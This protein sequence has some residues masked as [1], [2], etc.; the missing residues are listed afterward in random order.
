[1]ISPSINLTNVSSAILNFWIY[2]SGGSDFLQVFINNN[3]GAFTQ[4]GTNYGIYNNW[5]LI[6]I[7]IPSS[8]VGGA[9]SNVKLKFTGLS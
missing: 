1:M 9:N 4:I 2:N 6:S 5:T 7:N 3:N 8:F